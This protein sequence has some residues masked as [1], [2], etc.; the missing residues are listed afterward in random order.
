MRSCQIISVAKFD[1]KSAC[2]ICIFMTNKEQN[3]G[4]VTQPLIKH[5]SRNVVLDEASIWC[6]KEV[7][8]Q[9]Q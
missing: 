1:K 5:V 6:S 8:Y 3:E 9:T 7:S 4:V 2:C